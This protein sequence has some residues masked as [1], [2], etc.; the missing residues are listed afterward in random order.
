MEWIK[1]LFDVD[2]V[3]E[4]AISFG[5][6]VFTAFG[7][8]FWVVYGGYGIGSLPVDLL[9]GEK[10]LEQTKNDLYI[11]LQKIKQA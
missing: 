3:G 10:S 7:A 4:S 9:R 6:A 5:M 8:V 1:K 11:D 2:H